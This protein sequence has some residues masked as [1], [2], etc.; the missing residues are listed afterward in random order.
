ME[1]AVVTRLLGNLDPVFLTQ[2]LRRGVLDVELFRSIAEVMKQ[3]C[4]PW[5]DAM[6]DNCVVNVDNG[7]FDHAFEQLFECAEAMKVVS[8]STRPRT[9]LR[10]GSLTLRSGY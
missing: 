8:G 2:R 10:Y 5:R 7:Q 3:H 4:A 1:S 6:V 9:S